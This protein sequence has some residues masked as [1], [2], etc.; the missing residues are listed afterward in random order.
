[1]INLEV[2]SLAAAIL[3]LIMF[4]LTLQISMRRAALGKAAGDL[5][6]VV[7]GD[8]GDETLRRRIR[9]FGNFVEYVPICLLMLAIVEISDASK[10]LLWAVATLL[11][12]GRIIHAFGMLYVAHPAPRGLAMFMT[13]ASFL[14]PAIWLLIHRF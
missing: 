2:T 4:P 9:A 11:V 5:A 12:V 7:F 10:T 8:G 3:A 6:A 14:V 1:M 13:Y